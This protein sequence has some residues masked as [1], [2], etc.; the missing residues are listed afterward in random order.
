MI[1]EKND[2]RFAHPS[3]KSFTFA[4]LE[5]FTKG[6]TDAGHNFEIGDLF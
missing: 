2:A 1:L 3:K 4:V 6:L 5:A